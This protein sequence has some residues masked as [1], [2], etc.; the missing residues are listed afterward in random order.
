MPDEMAD[1]NE[2]DAVETL[3]V[4]VVDWPACVTAMVRV[5][6]PPVTVTVPVRAAVPVLAVTLTV[7]LPLLAPLAGVTVSQVWLS[8]AVQLTFA[9]TAPVAVEAAE[10]NERAVG[11]TVR[12]L[13]VGAACVTAIVRVSPPPVTVTVPVRAAVP[14]LAV[15]L[16]ETL[17]L[18]LPLTGEAVIHVWLSVTVQLTFAVTATGDDEAPEAND[19]AVGE[20]VRLLV[21]GPNTEANTEVVRMPF[22][23]FTM[24]LP[25]V[26]SCA[27]SK[28]T[29]MSRP[30][31]P[32]PLPD[33]DQPM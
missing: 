28:L 19:S 17:P 6:P 4:L 21:A 10:A 9:V 33:Q 11:V 15:T 24:R 25:Q 13:A 30:V 26:V 27:G 32:P 8:V 23:P 16:T 7:R 2:S 22:V 1:P 3:S 14:V 18:L 29:V 31:P 20:T 5:S 12:L